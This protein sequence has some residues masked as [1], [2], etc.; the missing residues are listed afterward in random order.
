MATFYIYSYATSMTNR[1][2]P[3]NCAVMLVCMLS[4][5]KILCRCHPANRYS[6]IIIIKCII[7]NQ[8]ILTIP[9]ENNTPSVP[10]SAQIRNVVKKSKPRQ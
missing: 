2:T 9:F 10:P 6:N 1:I 7:L 8:R 3:N 4:V 5:S